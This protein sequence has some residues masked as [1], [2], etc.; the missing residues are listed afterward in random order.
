ML[1]CFVFFVTVSQL[2]SLYETM[3]MKKLPHFGTV[4]EGEIAS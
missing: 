1:F 3:L 2:S 4:E